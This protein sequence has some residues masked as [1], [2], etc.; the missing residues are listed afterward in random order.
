MG[1]QLPL[2]TKGHSPHFSARVYCGQT[3][4]WI[5][6]PFGTEVGLGAYDIVLDEDPA[7]TERT[8]AVPHFLARVNCGQTVAHLTTA[9]LLLKGLKEEGAVPLSRSAGNPS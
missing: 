7:P 5:R 3:A 9:E 6:I 1:T 4:G 2:K 8:I